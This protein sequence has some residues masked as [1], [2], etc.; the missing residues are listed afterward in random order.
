MYKIAAA[1]WSHPHSVVLKIGAVETSVDSATAT[2]ED[3]DRVLVLL[4]LRGCKCL[5]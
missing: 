3:L 5:V 2:Q 1:A 4:T